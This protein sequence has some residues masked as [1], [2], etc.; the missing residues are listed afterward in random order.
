VTSNASVSV[1]EAR[2]LAPAVPAAAVK[3]SIETSNGPISIVYD[4]RQAAVVHASAKTSNAAV[5]VVHRAFG[6]GTF[7][8]RTS[9]PQGVQVEG[10]GVRD[11]QESGGGVQGSVGISSAEGNG[12]STTKVESSNA[13][14]KLRFE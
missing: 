4:H 6:A 11:R 9:G 1:A 2:L 12:G 14:V 5:K 13:G 3:A 7:H 8:G 10:E